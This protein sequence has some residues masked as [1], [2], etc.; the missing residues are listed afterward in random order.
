[1]SLVGKENDV[2]PTIIK[3]TYPRENQKV[4]IVDN[5]MR[6]K[7]LPITKLKEHLRKLNIWK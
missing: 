7:N 1:M 2:I 6:K 5:I 4:V 3:G